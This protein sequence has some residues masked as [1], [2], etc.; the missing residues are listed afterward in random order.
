MFS[1]DSSSGRKGSGLGS[2]AL[3]LWLSKLA[4]AFGDPPKRP[5]LSSSAGGVRSISFTPIAAS[6]S[7][8]CRPSSGR[9]RLLNASCTPLG[10]ES[11][12]SSDLPLTISLFLLDF[13]NLNF[14]RQNPMIATTTA[15]IP[16]AIPAM[17]PVPIPLDESEVVLVRPEL[18]LELLSSFGASLPL[19]A[20]V[21]TI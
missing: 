17:A 21:T 1:G 12:S 15:T 5:L 18:L 6:F 9:G 4:S 19:A 16:T 10:S 3:P 2:S 13:R 14:Q 11:P 20:L 7:F 8:S